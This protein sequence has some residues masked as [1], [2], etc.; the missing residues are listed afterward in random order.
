MSLT[1]RLKN[2]GFI[3]TNIIAPGTLI[4]GGPGSSG[5]RFGSFGSLFRRKTLRHFRYGT[6]I[7]AQLI[8]D[9]FKIQL[10]VLKLIKIT[11]YGI[12]NEYTNS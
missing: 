11:F 3:S 12:N 5:H 1:K 8:K 9:F 10:I 7:D 4:G 6:E 2:N